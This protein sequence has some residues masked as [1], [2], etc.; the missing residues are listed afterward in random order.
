M[1]IEGNKNFIQLESNSELNVLSEL[2][3]DISQ[4]TS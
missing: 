4:A 1:S 2:D 3:G